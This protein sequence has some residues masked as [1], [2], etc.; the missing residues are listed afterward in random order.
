MHIIMY[1]H[2]HTHT[3]DPSL[4]PSLPIETRII[5]PAPII[6]KHPTSVEVRRGEG[7]AVSF[8]CVAKEGVVYDWY[9]DGELKVKNCSEGKLV[10][11]RVKLEDQGEYYCKVSNDGGEEQSNLAR[12][13]FSKD[14]Q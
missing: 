2:I 3:I 6:Q 13:T 9:K 12:L 8:E 5:P 11:D 1:T 10:L 4:P 14:Y 7:R